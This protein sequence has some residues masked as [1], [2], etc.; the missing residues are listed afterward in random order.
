[1]TGWRDT[2]ALIVAI[3][4]RPCTGALFVLI[5][6]QLMGIGLAGV[7]GAFTMGL[8]TAMVTALVAV[9]A[10]WTREGALASLPGAGIARALP[11]V[12]VAA[13]AAIV[14]AALLLWGHSA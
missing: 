6:T 4:L 10:V 1:M 14:V 2:A 9:M 12:E 5:L 13:G 3:A 11:Y 8:G 7:I